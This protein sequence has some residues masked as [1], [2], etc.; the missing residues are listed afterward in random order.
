MTYDLTCQEGITNFL[1]IILCVDQNSGGLLLGG[2]SIVLYI[3]ILMNLSQNEYFPDVM[4]A[5]SFAMSIITGLLLFRFGLQGWVV[6]LNF[7]IFMASLI[8]KVWWRNE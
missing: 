8:Y 2:F 1:E 4:L 7:S 5:A 6:I 3:I